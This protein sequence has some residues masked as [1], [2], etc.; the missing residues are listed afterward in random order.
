MASRVIGIDMGS[1]ALRAVELELSDPPVIHRFGQVALPAG[2]VQDGEVVDVAAVTIALRRLWESVGFSTKSVRVG[3][4]STRMIIRIVEMPRLPRD[5]LISAVQLQLEDLVPLP[6]D[7]TVFDV[8]PLDE[9]DATVKKA[10]RR[11]VGGQAPQQ[12]LLA[13]AHRNALLPV[14]DAVRA[15]GLKLEGIDVVPAALARAL[16]S[17]SDET[18][19][20]DM[21]VALGADTVVVVAA[22]HGSPLFARTLTNI[23]G[24][25]VTE[26]IAARLDL[27]YVEA[28]R[29]K[30]WAV[31]DVTE[32][33]TAREA[34]GPSVEELIDEIRDSITYYSGNDGARPIR[35]VLLTGGGS[36]LSDIAEILSTR[37]GIPVE[38]ADPF[39]GLALG[40]IGFDP[41]DLPYLAPYAAA[42]IG[43]ALDGGGAKAGRLD[44]TP[45]STEGPRRIASRQLLV[46]SGVAVVVV[47]LGAFYMQ[48]R[49]AIDEEGAKAD[50]I[51]AQ[52][53]D[54]Q[55]KIEAALSTGSP[56]DA[57]S[58]RATP[59]AVVASVALR[60]VDWLKAS[61]QLE[62][63]S[64]PL[65][66]SIASLDGA[67]V[68]EAA[69]TQPQ[70]AAQAPDS[71]APSP[72]P[73]PA[74]VTVGRYNVT[75][76][77][78]DLNAIA[79]WL[80][81]ISADAHFADVWIGATTTAS[82][83][84]GAEGVQFTANL[85]LTEANLVQ[86]PYAPS[87]VQ[88]SR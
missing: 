52:L 43:V 80:D 23:S 82:L 73:T 37:L 76:T 40:R 45:S 7:E 65:G 88:E 75:A 8:Q 12:L 6:S 34:A 50:R 51:E 4:A 10:K 78:T 58:T 26:R 68:T 41:E 33:L 84:N 86:R 25:R 77:A 66:V 70:A 53:A 42:A 17:A 1:S 49:S 74:N 9:A 15:A 71:A 63:L 29:R 79:A 48:R 3:F 11:D 36:Q 87:R 32:A 56:S 81:A 54:V 59:Q 62:A 2:A 5:E 20:V 57:A 24:R 69:S 35:R 38:R 14:A 64:S 60:D 18:D 83:A 28:E 47:A 31:D 72:A 13:A 67:V 39:S 21:I 19:A 55:A 30:R 27:D 85:A 46:G 61:T 16:T 22:R 44:L